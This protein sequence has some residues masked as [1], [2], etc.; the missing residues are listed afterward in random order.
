[1]GIS[2]Y[3]LQTA[4]KFKER[5]CF[6][7]QRRGVGE[8]KKIIAWVG[9]VLLGLYVLAL[10]G[11]LVSRLFVETKTMLITLVLTGIPV[12]GIWGVTYLIDKR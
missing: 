9:A 5:S 1:M 7:F 11:F 10:V 3:E 6:I 2:D 4:F 12:L 8:M